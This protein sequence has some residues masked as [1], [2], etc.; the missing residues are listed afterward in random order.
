MNGRIDN[1]GAKVPGSERVRE[2]KFQGAKWPGSESSMERKGPGA[3]VPES[4]LARVLLELS[5]PGAKRPG[6]VFSM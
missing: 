3:K 2:R 4:E 6:T 1:M 5:L